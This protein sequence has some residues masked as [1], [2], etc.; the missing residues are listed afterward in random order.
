MNI[1]TQLPFVLAVEC[2]L[3]YF[4]SIGKIKY[5]ILYLKLM[6]DNHVSS[7]L[8]YSLQKLAA[9]VGASPLGDS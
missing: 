9:E 8:P 6:I 2:K 4:Q 3:Q 5:N 1:R 7:K